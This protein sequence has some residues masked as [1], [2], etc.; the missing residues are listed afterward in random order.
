MVFFLV[1]PEKGQ[2]LGCEMR[3]AVDPGRVESPK[4]TGEGGKVQALEINN[5]ES[6]DAYFLVIRSPSADEE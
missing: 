4:G 3:V 1:K 2:E 5:P 6:S